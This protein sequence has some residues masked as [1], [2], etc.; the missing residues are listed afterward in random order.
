MT[1]VPRAS[2]FLLNT[3]R[4]AA[5]TCLFPAYLCRKSI[6]SRAFRRPIHTKSGRWYLSTKRTAPAGYQGPLSQHAKKAAPHIGSGRS[7]SKKLPTRLKASQSLP[8]E[9]Q[10][11]RKFV[12]QEDMRLRSDSFHAALC[13]IKPKGLYRQLEAASHIGCGLKADGNGVLIKKLH[14][15]GFHDGFQALLDAELFV[16]A[17]AVVLDGPFCNK[18][19]VGDFNI[20]A[21]GRH[22]LQNLQFPRA[23]QA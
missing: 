23:Q 22:Q 11:N 2:L 18:Q 8:P 4:K 17:R 16:Y 7:L 5:G 1:I 14:F 9:R 6:I 20:R 10:I 19:L 21:F 15:P 3:V 12:T 13:R